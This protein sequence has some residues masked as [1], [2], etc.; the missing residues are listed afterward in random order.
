MQN[1]PWNPALRDIEHRK[2]PRNEENTT[3]PSDRNRKKLLRP[4][5]KDGVLVHCMDPGLG[6]SVAAQVERMC[7]PLLN[8]DEDESEDEDDSIRQ[9]PKPRFLKRRTKT[10]KKRYVLPIIIG[11]DADAVEIMTCPDSGSD[12][13]IMSLEFVNRL[14]LKVHG[15]GH[16]PRRFS[17][18]NGKITEAMGQVTAQCSFGAGSPSDISMLGCIF[19]VF[20]SLAVPVI[21]G[22]EFLEQTETL[23]KHRDRLVEQL[24]PSMQALRVNS[25]GR[26]RRNLICRLDN[27]VGCASADTGSD[28]DLVSLEFARSRAFNI[29][30]AYEQLEFADCSVGHTL[31]IINASFSVGNLS[32]VAGFLPRGDVVDLEFYVLEDLNADILVGQDTI[33]EL[34]IFSLHTESFIPSI[35]KL[36]ESDV[37]II[38]H[39][40]TL[41]RLASKIGNKIKDKFLSGA[42]RQNTD[43]SI[44]VVAEFGLEDQR[45]NARR[46][47]ARSEIEKLTGLAKLKANE[48]EAARI[49][50]FEEER[51]TRLKCH[52]KSATNAKSAGSASNSDNSDSSTGTRSNM[53]SEP[54]PRHDPPPTSPSAD[55]MFV[56]NGT[57]PRDGAFVCTF[58]GCTAQPFQTQ[59]LLNTHANVHS[60]ARPHYCPIRGCPRSEGGRGFKRKNEMIRHGLVH[61]SPGYVCPFCP[62]REHKYPRP[63][64]LARHVRVHHVD[65]DKDDPIL[66]EGLEKRKGEILT[67]PSR[68]APIGVAWWANSRGSWI[69]RDGSIYKGLDR[70]KNEQAKLFDRVML[71]DPV[72]GQWRLTGSNFNVIIYTEYCKVI[73]T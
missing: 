57:S 62:D 21:I 40:G 13:N 27:Y 43:T 20:K 11:S 23:S 10:Q 9:I 32:G 59:Y 60:S 1:S 37:N 14:G 39:I 63:D 19:H 22:M 50:K 49:L 5:R 66:Q 42:S 16:E 4:S 24:V 65:K 67:T 69:E 53:S 58:Q 12:E 8:D 46:E 51:E 34:D 70:V 38:R 56:N 68:Q 28:L 54:L 55:S 31:G 41:E 35:P 33:D 73:L 72:Q 71:V 44:H 6:W 45:E 25:V 7:L 2:R 61:D 29:E 64:N 48:D 52:L 3:K 18:A 17:L 36:G 15:S 26:P 30:P 47:A